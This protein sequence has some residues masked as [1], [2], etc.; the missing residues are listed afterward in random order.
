MMPM[1]TK[2]S[3]FAP[4]S[5]S[6]LPTCGPTNSL[7]D[8]RTGSAA[9]A[10]AD[11]AA[12]RLALVGCVSLRATTLPPSALHSASKTRRDDVGLLDVAAHR[13]ADQHVA[14]AAEV[15]HLHVAEAQPLDRRR[16]SCR[17]RPA[18]RSCDLDHRAAGELDREVQAARG[19]EEHRG[20]EGQQRDD[21]EHQRMPHERDV[22]AGCGRTP[23]C[24]GSR[25]RSDGAARQVLAGA[26]RRRG[27]QTWPIDTRLQPLLAAVPEV[28]QAAREHHR[29]EHRGQDAQ[30]V[31]D[32]EAAHRPGAEGEQRQAGDQRRDVRVE[33]GREGALVAGVD[34][35]LR[36]RRRRAAPRGCAR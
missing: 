22:A 16:G 33:D 5:A 32:R 28:D 4:S 3:A 15:L 27:F 6:S 13:H 34:R 31:H 20:E 8:S 29:R 14:R 21:V 12:D 18:A 1:T 25:E 2:A 10:D 24:V 9:P 30:A 19:E 23:S 17:C 7:R 35:R 36:R 11:L 26:R